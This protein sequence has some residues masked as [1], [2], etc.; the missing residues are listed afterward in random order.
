MNDDDCRCHGTMGLAELI[1]RREVG[2]CEVVETAIA[3]IE[4]RE[5]ALNAV[6]APRFDSARGAMPRASAPARP[7]AP[8]SPCPNVSGR[9]RPQTPPLR[10]AGRR[11]PAPGLRRRASR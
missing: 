10:P 7:G 3:Q 2:A 4:A 1:S 5:P 6:I 8:L 9:G 11:P